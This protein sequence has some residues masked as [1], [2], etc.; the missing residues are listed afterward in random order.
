MSAAGGSEIGAG[1][2]AGVAQDVVEVWLDDADRLWRWRFLGRDGT[3]LLSNRS[4]PT[5][6]EAATA[7]SVAYPGVPVRERPAP[8][9]RRPRGRR[10]AWLIGL[11]VVA[12]ILT[13]GL[14]M[15]VIAAVAAAALAA[16]L[17]RSRVRG[18]RR[19]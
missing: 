3:T 1:R 5:H 6:E 2:D 8:G 13:A 4:F 17:V 19:G 15:V 12:T 14:A 7:A 18:V 11:V 9:T 16:K 10:P